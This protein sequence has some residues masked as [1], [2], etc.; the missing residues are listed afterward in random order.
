MHESPDGAPRTVGKYTVLSVLGRGAMGVVYRARDSV[1]ERDV[2]LKVMAPQ[3]AAAGEQ[4]KARFQREAKA[5]ARVQH[6]NVVTV[7][8][9][10]AD[11]DGSPYIVMELLSGR[12]LLVALR[13]E[14]L[15]L[16]QKIDVIIQTLDGLSHAHAA[17]VVHRD[18][19]PENIFIC[20]NGLVKVT[21][22]GIARL[23]EHTTTLAM[24][25]TPAYM[26]PEQAN[27]C[28]VDYRTD[29]FSVGTVIYE[30]LLG[31]RPFDAATTFG[32]LYKIVHEE[33]DYA[34][35]A[36]QSQYGPF[37]GIVKTA[38]QK[39]PSLRF[40]TARAFNDAL[41]SA[42]SSARDQPLERT[43]A[44]LTRQTSTGASKAG[45]A[46]QNPISDPQPDDA[47]VG[48]VFWKP[49]SE[50]SSGDIARLFLT[51]DSLTKGGDYASAEEL[52][53]EIL[54]RGLDFVALSN[55]ALCRLKLGQHDSAISDLNTAISTFPDHPDLATPYNILGFTLVELK[56]PTQAISYFDRALELS[57]TF[58]EAHFN[59]G[60]ACRAADRIEDAIKSFDSFLQLAALPH[61]RRLVPAATTHIQEL[62]A[63]LK[64]ISKPDVQ[65]AMLSLFGHTNVEEAMRQIGWSDRTKK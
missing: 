21:D 53:S 15:A 18:I 27:R 14:N 65:K 37:L 5:L 16:E 44:D 55:R 4:A 58:A 25:G 10:G 42:L 52:Y 62:N 17:N 54:A 50:A 63:Q 6:P 33:P 39:D 13:S 64:I 45:S 24:M 41:K 2:A 46:M 34:E 20:S 11:P 60:A 23:V 47:T 43:P 57:P 31:R 9:M 12:N 36:S 3:L 28:D 49:S 8:D 26:S 19:K 35:F 56:Q 7:H 1:L 32:V 38:L 40:Q 61:H 48:I 51:A 22:F 59:R 30:V 29:L